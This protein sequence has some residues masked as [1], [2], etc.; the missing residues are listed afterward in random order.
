MADETTHEAT[1]EST[2][3]STPTGDRSPRFFIETWGCQMNELDTQRMAGQLMQQGMLPT[4]E[5]DDADVLLLN[6]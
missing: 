4:R 5:P 3:K 1:A 6:S 2:P